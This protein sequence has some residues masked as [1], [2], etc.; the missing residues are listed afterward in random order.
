MALRIS[1]Q[2]TLPSNDCP[3]PVTITRLSF[4]VHKPGGDD[5][6][7]PEILPRLIPG[8]DRERAVIGEVPAPLPLMLEVGE[9][10][11]HGGIEQVEVVVAEG[12]E[13][14]QPLPRPGWRAT[15]L[16]DQGCCPDSTPRFRSIA[17]FSASP[18]RSLSFDSSVPIWRGCGTLPSRRSR[19]SRM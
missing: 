8:L 11:Q 19:Y 3:G 10:V 18:T 12:Q 17:R 7:H 1:F 5:A 9:R 16:D 14:D 4:R 6:P 13:P 15:P 2:V